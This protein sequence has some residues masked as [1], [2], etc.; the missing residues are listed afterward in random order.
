MIQSIGVIIA[1]GVIWWKPE[2]KIADP[3]CT[4][5]FSIIVLFTTWRVATDCIKIL[6]EGTPQE[7]DTDEFEEG[8]KSVP[9]VI[10]IH[11]LHVWSLSAG[12]PAM[13][14]HILSSDMRKTLKY[15]TRFAR[16]Y[17]IFHSTIQV[18]EADTHGV[19][20]KTVCAHNIH[21]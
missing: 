11:D 16:E 1:A 7:L 2:W 4:F 14:A 6:L 21:N 9:G 12:R 19:P 15:A 17:G 18:E 10:D 20:I 13:S 3:I 8:L 5:V